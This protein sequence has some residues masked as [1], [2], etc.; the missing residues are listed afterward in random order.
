MKIK[1]IL[2]FGATSITIFLQG[3]TTSESTHIEKQNQTI[4]NHGFSS[5]GLVIAHL[6]RE[7]SLN[8]HQDISP[9]G[10][11]GAIIK[12]VAIDGSQKRALFRVTGRSIKKPLQYWI[13]AGETFHQ[14]SI[15]GTEGIVLT[16]VTPKDV[17]ILVHS[18]DVIDNLGKGA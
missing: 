12:L 4:A 1:E 16:E 6:S 8:P 2:L 17:K 10:Y 5:P 14:F 15:F 3:C 13:T 18:V 9:A 11:P 7:Y